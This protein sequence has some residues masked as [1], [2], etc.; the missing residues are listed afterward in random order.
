MLMM[1]AL[2]AQ[3]EVSELA[4]EANDTHDAGRACTSRGPGARGGGK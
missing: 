1:L 3:L 4:A 2:L